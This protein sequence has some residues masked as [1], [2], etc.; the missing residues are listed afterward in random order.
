LARSRTEGSYTR[1][2]ERETEIRK[3]RTEVQILEETFQARER[4]LRSRLKIVTQS[5]EAIRQRKAFIYRQEDSLR[6]KLVDA[7]REQEVQEPA[8]QE[9]QVVGAEMEADALSEGSSRYTVKSVSSYKERINQSSV[10]KDR[11][12]TRNKTS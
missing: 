8:E 2:K 10:S 3:A 4:D 12:K 11:I 1:L 9:L 7:G 5:L 6:Q